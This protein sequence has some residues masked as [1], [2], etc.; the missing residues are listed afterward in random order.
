MSQRRG[1]RRPM[2]RAWRSPSS[3]ATSTPAR[4]AGSPL[5][6]W[7][8]STATAGWR[9]SRPSTH[10]R[11]R[12]AGPAARQRHGD[13]GPGLRAGVVA[14]LEGD[15]VREI[16]VGGNDGTVAAYDFSGGGLQTKAGWPASTCSDGQSPETRGLAAADLDG[17]GRVEV[18]ATT[19]NTSPTTAR[20]SSSS[21]R[22][23]AGAARLAPLQRGRRRVQRRGQP[24]L[25]RLR[26]ERRHRQPR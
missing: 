8:T 5:R 9:S 25:R 2:A 13:R 7:S 14:D 16:V 26:R 6:A 3:C 12:R 11:L 15:G 1:P 18:V 4:R 21:T 10:V 23:A 19:T 22:P 24:G 20:R 17:D